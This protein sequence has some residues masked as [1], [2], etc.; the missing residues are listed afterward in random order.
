G[1][2]I[3]QTIYEH[4]RS[5]YAL[6]QPNF[7]SWFGDD[8]WLLW[9]SLWGLYFGI[10]VAGAA[11]LFHR[12]RGMTTIYNIDP[13]VFDAAFARVLD[14]YLG[15]WS[16][17]GNQ[18]LLSD[19]SAPGS[20]SAPPASPPASPWHSGPSVAPSSRG[21]FLVEVDSFPALRHVTLYWRDAT[22][23]VRRE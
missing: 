6:K 1:P 18:I 12:R 4:Q 14:R 10:V 5:A 22:I 13:S 21:Q 2:D 16:R 8:A 7:L 9:A 23:K 3:L 19:R 20:A 15:S 11:H 17:S